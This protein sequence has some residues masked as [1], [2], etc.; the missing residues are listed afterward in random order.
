MAIAHEHLSLE[1]FLQLPEEEPSLEYVNGVI[2]QKPV[3]KVEHSAIQTGLARRVDDFGVPQRVA[4]AFVELRVTFASVSRVPE[5]SIFEWLRI[6]MDNRGYLAEAFE[7]P[8]VAIEIGS[9]DQSLNVLRQKCFWYVAKGVRVAALIDPEGMKISM[10]RPQSMPVVL[11]IGDRIDLDDVLPDMGL[12]VDEVF[13][14]LR[15]DVSQPIG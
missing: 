7:P 1:E 2:T 11:G 10:F 13:G 15:A 5:V 14:W 9:P 6:P 12:S 4:R 8:D 3:P